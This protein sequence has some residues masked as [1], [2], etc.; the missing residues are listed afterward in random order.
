VDGNRAVAAKRVYEDRLISSWL[1]TR[2]GEGVNNVI[3]IIL[4]KSLAQH[5]AE[6]KQKRFEADMAAIGAHNAEL[7]VR[8]MAKLIERES[9]G[10]HSQEK[11]LKKCGLKRGQS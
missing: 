11:I 8:A 10:E 4:E 1:Q 2:G 9:N 5:M 6:Y 3:V 7:E